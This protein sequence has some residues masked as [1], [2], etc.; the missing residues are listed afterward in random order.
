MHVPLVRALI[1]RGRLAG[2]VPRR[3]ASFYEPPHQVGHNRPLSDW[4]TQPD[5]VALRK[6]R[7]ERRPQP[8]AGPRLAVKSSDLHLLQRRM[9]YVRSWEQDGSSTTLSG[10]VRRGHRAWLNV[11]DVQECRSAGDLPG[12]ALSSH[13]GGQGFKSPQLHRVSCL[14][15]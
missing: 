12:C 1:G 10:A 14:R 7:P 13:R 6:P 15:T 3:R 9:S 2:C 5:A 8:Q 4:V 11:S